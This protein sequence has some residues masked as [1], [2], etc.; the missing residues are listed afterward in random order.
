MHDN[1]WGDV[2]EPHSIVQLALRQGT[3]LFF[4]MGVF[5]VP[6]ENV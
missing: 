5:L 6:K 3:A 2:D 1:V 4:Y